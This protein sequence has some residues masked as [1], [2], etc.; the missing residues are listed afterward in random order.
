M[1]WEFSLAARLADKRE[2]SFVSIIIR[3]ASVAV[4]L[5]MAVM[6]VTT[7]LIAG[8]K[9]EISGKIF[10]FWGHLHV[11][12]ANV[13]H[14]L[15][16]VKPIEADTVLQQRIQSMPGIKGVQAFA[17]QAGIVRGKKDLDG[18]FLKGIGPDFNRDAFLPFL[19]EG[20][21]PMV[22]SNET[23][24]EMVIS[25][26]TARR[27]QVK[28]GDRFRLFFVRNGN[29]LRRSFRIAGIYKTGLE[30][31]DSKF[32]LVDI[33]HVRELQGW[34]PNQIGGY[35]IFVD[36][37]RNLDAWVDYLHTRVLPPNLQAQSIR[38]KIPEIFEWLTL[39]D[40]NEVVILALMAVVAIINMVTALLILILERT[41]MVGILKSLG[42]SDWGIRRLFLQYA[43][44]I[45]IRGML[46]GNMLG[47]SLCLLQKYGHFV[48]L[49][50]ENYYL[51]EA[52][53]LLRLPDILALN[54]VT[55]VVILLFM[56]LPSWLITRIAPVRTLRLD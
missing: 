10:G 43:G 4:A 6:L 11:Q 45:A 39:Q 18:L 7:A 37:V 50:E 44:I 15:L 46:W 28:T 38:E 24:R 33:Q 23:T 54:L 30:E 47:I 2:K 31:Y 20:K 49:S 51:S 26:Q 34:G 1:S 35:E 56:L 42:A 55:L 16:E 14:S 27:L 5:S 3:I 25:R 52:P 9:T 36:D 22:A 29:L 48:K 12:T 13:Y 17:L 8:F 40:I 21:L 19:Q 41:R 32:A 53:I